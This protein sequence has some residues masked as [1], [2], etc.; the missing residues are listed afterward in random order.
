M[1]LHVLKHVTQWRHRDNVGVPYLKDCSTFFIRRHSAWEE[2]RNI[3]ALK[4]N[5]NTV[6][7][8]NKTERF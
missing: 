1:I 4:K 6:Y 5:Q 2:R 7:L 8:I 3:Q